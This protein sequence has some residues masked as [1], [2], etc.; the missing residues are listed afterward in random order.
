MTVI[1]IDELFVKNTRTKVELLRGSH[2]LIYILLKKCCY[3]AISHTTINEKQFKNQVLNQ[4][5]NQ[6]INVIR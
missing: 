3:I 6:A 1:Y 2:Y 5:Q 4:F